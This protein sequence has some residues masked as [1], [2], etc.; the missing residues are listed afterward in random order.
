VDRFSQILY[1]LGKE[2]QVDLYADLN[3][4]CEI[5]CDDQIH[6]QL[7]FNEGKEELMLATFVCDVPPGKYREQLLRAGLI[8][9][10][11]SPTSGILSYSERNNQLTLHHTLPAAHLNGEKVFRAFEDFV[12]K[13]LE[14]KDA[15]ENGK[16]LPINPPP[17][18]GGIFGMKP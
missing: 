1:D 13:A 6:V 7:L 8:S 17:S 4:V 14:W 16:P 3:Q 10:F 18:Q 5:N 11:E 15:V 2:L 12:A 9:N